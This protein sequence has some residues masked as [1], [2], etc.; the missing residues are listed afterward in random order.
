MYA[1]TLVV[2]CMDGSEAVFNNCQ[3]TTDTESL[4]AEGRWIRSVLGEMR[5][6]QTLPDK[7]GKPVPVTTV[8]KQSSYVEYRVSVL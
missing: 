2:V 3:F 7:D 8:F 6:Q 4:M 1:P 5:I